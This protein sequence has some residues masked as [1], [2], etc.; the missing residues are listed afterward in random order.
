MLLFCF[1]QI[2]NVKRAISLSVPSPSTFQKRIFELLSQM[3]LLYTLYQ[4]A[5]SDIKYKLVEEN[6]ATTNTGGKRISDSG[7]N[8]LLGNIY[9]RVGTTKNIWQRTIAGN[10][11]ASWTDAEENSTERNSVKNDS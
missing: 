3:T 4:I 5:K 11:R 8:T 2:L 9:S 6:M 7:L 1:K 10:V